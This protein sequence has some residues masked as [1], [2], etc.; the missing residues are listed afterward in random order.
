MVRQCLENLRRGVGAPVVDADHLVVRDTLERL[1]DLGEQSLDVLGL[2][3]QGDHDGQPRG[4]VR[5]G[6]VVVPSPRLTAQ[7]I[8]GI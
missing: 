3:V 8:S 1:V 2:V 6:S 5:R 4:W 7:D